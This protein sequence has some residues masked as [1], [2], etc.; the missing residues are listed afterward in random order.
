MVSLHSSYLHGEYMG[1]NRRS[2]GWTLENGYPKN[3]EKDTFPRRAMSAGSKAGLFLLLRAYEQDLD[4][5]CR[6][7]V[8]GFKVLLHHPA[9]VPRVGTQYF[10]APLNQEIVVAVK[11]DMMTTSQGLRSYEPHR[12]QCFFAEERQLQFFQNYTQQNCQVECVANF[13]LAKCG[14]VAYHMPRKK[15]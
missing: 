8:Q 11:P 3:A 2:E 6:G 14:C 13:T 5:V 10:R 1:H 12:R 15:S 9:E 7:P 4:Y